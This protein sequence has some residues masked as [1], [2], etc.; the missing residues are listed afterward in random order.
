MVIL[1]TGLLLQLLVLGTVL[2][3]PKLVLVAVITA[4]NLLQSEFQLIL[5]DGHIW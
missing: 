4:I 2:T 3:W 1:E 5:L